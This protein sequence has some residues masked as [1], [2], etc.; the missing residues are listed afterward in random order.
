MPLITVSQF[1][2][3]HKVTPQAIRFYMKSKKIKPQ[4]VFGVMVVDSK[5][6]YKRVRGKA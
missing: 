6:K 3:K 5:M 1:A 4:V 2:K